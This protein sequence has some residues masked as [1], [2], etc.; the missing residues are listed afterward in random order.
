MLS[1]A[2]A[3]PTWLGLHYPSDVLARAALGAVIAG[4]SLTL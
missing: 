1:G 2:Q 4:I 3:H